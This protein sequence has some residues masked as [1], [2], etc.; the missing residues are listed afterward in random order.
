WAS[1][2]MPSW[3]NLAARRNRCGRCMKPERCDAMNR[4]PRSYLFVPASRP[5]RIGKALA[6]GAD[7]VI[8]DFEDAVA[9]D[10]KV[11]ARDGLAAS[12]PGLQAQARAADVALLVRIN[13]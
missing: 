13:G 11:Q 8:V 6:A 5:E 2:P 3:P 12:W 10:A 1:I 7:A 4:L 9:P